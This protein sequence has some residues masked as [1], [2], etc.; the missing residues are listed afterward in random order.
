MRVLAAP[1]TF[2]GSL[3]AKNAAR[4]LGDVVRAR[5]HDVDEAPLADGGEGTLDALREPWRLRLRATRV[6]GPLGQMTDARWGVSDVFVDVARP[7]VKQ[8]APA[9]IAL[10]EAAEVVGLGLLP[11][12]ARDPLSATTL[13]LGLLVAAALDEGARHVFIGLG[14]TATVDGGAGLLAALGVRFFDDGGAALTPRPRDLARAARVDLS[15]LHPGLA[16]ATLTG[17]VDVDVP[18]LGPGG[19]R[20]FMAQKGADEA[21]MAVLEEALAR[22]HPPEVADVPGAGAAGGLGAALLRL[23]GTLTSGARAVCDAL[24]IDARVARADLVFTGEGRIDEQTVH[25]KLVAALAA[26][27]RRHGR[28]L[29]AFCGERAGDPATLAAAGLHDIVVITPPGQGLDEALACA[30]ENLVAAADAVF[31]RRLG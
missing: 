5:G 19:A 28:P 15:A 31:L 22:L 7:G 9:R 3:T 25:G 17:L 1:C 12:G 6:P 14:G 30:G 18:L 13:G 10:L 4:S 29:V 26:S 8:E 11:S 2:K 27:C 24:D 16:G 23:G 21:A 20:L